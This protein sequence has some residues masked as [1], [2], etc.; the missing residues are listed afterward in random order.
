M[1]FQEIQPT[2]EDA[3][4][5]MEW[6][7]DPTTLRMFYHSTPKKMPE[8]YDEYIK[9]YFSEPQCPAVFAMEGD[10][11]IAFLRFCSYDAYAH[12]DNSIVDISINVPPEKRHK[13]IGTRV[14]QAA[15]EYLRKKEVAG[16]MA[17]IKE[18]NV[19]SIRAFER[20]GYAYIDTKRKAI[21]GVRDPITI[22]RLFKEL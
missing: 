12:A 8:F 16:V 2:M 9:A 15:S 14:L 3:E 13:G 1:W 10:E 4:T 19:A 5:I 17:E 7:N 21:E 20:A 22:V 18:E 11:R 6:R